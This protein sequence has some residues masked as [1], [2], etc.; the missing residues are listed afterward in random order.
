MN[1]KLP[2]TENDVIDAVAAHLEGRDRRIEIVNRTDKQ[3]FDILVRRKKNSLAME[4]KGGTSSK[5]GTN[6]Y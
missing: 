3:G 6:R 4:A 1:E 2:L 5:S